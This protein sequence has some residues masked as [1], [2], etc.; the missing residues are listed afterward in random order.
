VKPLVNK[1]I[2]LTALGRESDITQCFDEAL[3]R[4]KG[5]AGHPDIVQM[6]KNMRGGR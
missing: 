3:R 4:V 5:D 2:A 1:V 6:K